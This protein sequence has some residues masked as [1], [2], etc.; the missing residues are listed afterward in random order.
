MNGYAGTI[1][2]VDLTTGKVTKEPLD[3]DVARSFIGGRGMAIKLGYDL[4]E[5]GV[6]PYSPDNKVIIG[7]G[8]LT[9]TNV[10]AS[11]RVT[12]LTRLPING[13]LGWGSGGGMNFGCMLKHAGYDHIVIEGRA[14]N[15][16]Y[17]KI[18]DDDVEI[19]DA[20]TLWGKGSHETVGLLNN[21]YGGPLGVISIGQG[22]ENL[23]KFAMTFID[24]CAHLGRGGL[25]AVFGSKNLKA[26]IARGTKGTAVADRKSYRALVEPL[27]E[28]MR[29]YPLREQYQKYGFMMFL[30][31]SPEAKEAY[32]ELKKARI[33]CVSCPIADKELF[34]VRK[35][36]CRGFTKYTGGPPPLDSAQSL[37][38]SDILDQYGLDSFETD[39]LLKFADELYRR[40]ILTEDRLGAA[41]ID[42]D[43]YE[44]LSGWYRKIA[45]REGF[46]NVLADGLKDVLQEYGE[47]IEEFAPA[48]VKGM[49][50]Y[51]GITGPV[52]SDLFGTFEFGMAVHPRGPHASSGGSSP[53]YFTRGRPPDWVKSHLDRMGAP[54][55]A[56]DRMF[57]PKD[58]MAVNVGR[59][60]KY[61]QQWL[62]TCDCLGTCSRGQIARF[63][64]SNLQAELYSAVTGFE[65]SREDLTQA[66][67]R[68][69]NLLKALNVREGFDRKDD[70]FPERWFGEKKHKDYYEQVDITREV[71]Y[72]LLDDYYDEMGWDIGTG[73]PTKSK[74]SELGLDYVIEDAEK[75]GIVYV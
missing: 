33:A 63:Y 15:P 13:A 20:G 28:R 57:T 31:P 48:E 64:S 32:L 14:M 25:G 6:D 1:L 74:L 39:A 47:G 72:G 66:A 54:Q 36:K 5:P 67:E 71:A 26:I 70:R 43:G 50:A 42:F 2:H 16:V 35:G 19:C 68:A 34:E 51:Q 73:I 18:F 40:S 53:L 17:L 30:G 61:S 21:E 38:L 29:N 58:G 37:K 60:E 52:F 11:C 56:I 10:P 7:A 59:M 3:L 12:S 75:L 4:I 55:D 22:G 65:T 27:Y 62:L 41:G 69:F 8:V 46:G 44:A 24:R 45:Y 23:V 49:I 9:G